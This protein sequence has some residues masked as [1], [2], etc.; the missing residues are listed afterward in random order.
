ML[1]QQL[2]LS[3][4]TARSDDPGPRLGSAP[5]DK[6][7]PAL[8]PDGASAGMTAEIAAAP[9][10]ISH[11]DQPYRAVSGASLRVAAK[12]YSCFNKAALSSTPL[13][14]RSCLRRRRSTPGMRMASKPGSGAED[15]KSRRWRST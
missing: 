10:P 11:Y 15:F 4:R 7:V 6:W 9:Q 8:A 5:E 3:C 13:R 1:R 12:P 14:L 2:Q